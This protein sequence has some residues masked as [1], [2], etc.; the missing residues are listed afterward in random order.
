MENMNSKAWDILLEEEK[1]ALSLS[2]NHSKSTWQ[3]G[4]ILDK[5]HYKYLEIHARAKH[6]FVIFTGYF[7]LTGNQLIPENSEISWDFR[8]FLT[9][10]IEKR[11]GYREA[12]KGVGKTSPLCSKY[13]KERDETLYNY[14]EWLRKHK[15][16][17]HQELYNIVKEFDRWNNFR[18]LP[19]AIQ[20][21]SAFKRRNKTRLLKHLRNVHSL[22]PIVID[23]LQTKSFRP[24]KYYPPLYLPIISDNYVKGYEVLKVSSASQVVKYISK[25]L[26]LYIF[27]NEELADDY[28]HLVENYLTNKDRHCTMGQKF[29]PQFRE[30]I[31]L[32]TN[33][34]D[35]NNII[36][37]KN[38]L[39]EAF[40]NIDKS[41][42]KKIE[43]RENSKVGKQ[44]E[45]RI[46]SDKLWEL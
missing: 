26:N 32:A 9:L 42:I 20:E 27:N 34:K 38:N 7:K 8:E 39:E 1:A 44:G 11:K 36:S 29:W 21:P 25:E 18:I 31:K 22:K 30:M 3:A 41:T 14:V 24:T 46:N 33:Y 12:L 35:V 45:E 40:L 17:L 5:A 15:C 43:D 4:E 10:T 37:R 6:F 23:Q 28:A 16:P 13:A 19:E 2:I